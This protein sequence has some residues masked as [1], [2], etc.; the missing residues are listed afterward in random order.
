MKELLNFFVRNSKWFVF[1]ILMVVSTFLLVRNDPYHQNIYLTSAN[2]VSSTIYGWTSNVTSYFNLRSNN[3]DLNERNAQLQ[4][5]VLALREQLLRAE[6]KGLLDSLNNDPSLQQFDFVTAHVINNSV[7]RP[8]NY[9]TINR[10]SN[11]GIAPEMGVLDQNGVVGVVNVVGPH[12]ARVISLLNPHFRL[13]CK[14]KGNDS[15]GSLVWDGEDPRYAVIEELP[16][17]TVFHQGDTI[18]TSGYSAVFPAGIPVGIVEADN[19]SG[20]EN[21][22]SLKV[23]LLTD[24]TTLNN[25]Q[26]VVNH[27]AAELRELEVEEKALEEKK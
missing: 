8:H 13:S 23:R 26:V 15:F 14:I 27:L 11:D 12:S 4:L 21:F 3:E 22:F 20:N 19:T 24:F 25:V 5:E 1:A 9:M 17:H 18:I 2:S 10:G 16:R 7:M 6:E